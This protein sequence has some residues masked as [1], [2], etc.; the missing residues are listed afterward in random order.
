VNGEKVES[1]EDFYRKLWRT[2]VGQEVT[3]V[4][5]RESRF[6]VITLRPIDRYQLLSLPGK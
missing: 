2:E 1:Q 3:I 4:V 5:L 6:H